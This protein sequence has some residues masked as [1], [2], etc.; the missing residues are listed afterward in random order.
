MNG[1]IV[2]GNLVEVGYDTFEFT[3][4][5]G[6][7]LEADQADPS[8]ECECGIWWDIQVKAVGLVPEGWEE[9]RGAKT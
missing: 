7:G 1:K 3:C 8:V 6:R 4:R 2:H 9:E 5:C